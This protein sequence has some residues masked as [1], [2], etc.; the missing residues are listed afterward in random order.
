M[1]D[2]G[3]NK[4]LGAGLATAL[5]L[6]ALSQ[7]SSVMFGGG[8]HGGGHHDGEAKSYD[9]IAAERYAYYISTGAGGHDAVEEAPFDLGLLL[10]GADISKGERSLN[11]KCATCHTWNDGGA[12]GTGPNIYA[13]MGKDIAAVSGFSYSSGLAEL[14]G[15]WTY[16]QMNGWLENPGAHVPGTKMAFAGLRKEPERMNAIAYLA[17]VTPNAP[18]FPDPLPAVIEEAS[19]EGDEALIETALTEETS[20]EEITEAVIEEVVAEVEAPVIE[21]PALSFTAGTGEAGLLGFVIA[22]TEPCTDASCWFTCADMTFISGGSTLDAA[23]ASG[24]LA[25]LKQILDTY[26][27]VQLKVGGYTDNTGNTAA[28]V[29]LS[30]A[31]ADAVAAALIGLGV[32]PERVVAEGYGEEFPV[33]SNDTDEGRAANRRIDVRVRE[34]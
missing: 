6:M 16:E 13:I 30:Q 22:E 5:G 14:P 33:A 21:I 28:N 26:P 31:R 8:G 10:A 2:L 32:A 24:Q 15:T 11:G 34:R 18:A 1:S 27:S 25:S 7:L 12:D 9:E 4:I 23:T 19:H 20:V 29:E 17:S 3:M